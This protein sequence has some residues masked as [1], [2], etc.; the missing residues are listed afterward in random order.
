M[1]IPPNIT[2][3]MISML[4]KLEW[5]LAGSQREVADGPGLNWLQISVI[6]CHHLHCS[7]G[8]L[9]LCSGAIFSS[10]I[11]TSLECNS[12]DLASILPNIWKQLIA[13]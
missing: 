5:M 3:K 13:G 6:P 11:E 12:S 8:Q 7:F 2:G 9:Y 10:R 1:L 4:L